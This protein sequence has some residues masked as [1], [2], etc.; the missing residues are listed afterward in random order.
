[1]ESETLTG[2]QSLNKGIG[3]FNVK[4]KT[5]LIPQMDRIGT[6][7]LAGAFRGFS[8]HAKVLET[9]KGLDIGKE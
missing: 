3:T 1:M 9:C 5:F 8:I 7:L 4:H 2:F 6:H